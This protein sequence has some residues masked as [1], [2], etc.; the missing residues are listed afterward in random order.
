MASPRLED[1]R[2][3]AAVLESGATSESVTFVAFFEYNES[4]PFL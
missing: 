2:R 1:R 4:S 3:T